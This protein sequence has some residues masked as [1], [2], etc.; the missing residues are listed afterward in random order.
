MEAAMIGYGK[1]VL[2]VD[3]DGRERQETALV[4]QQA[5]F[6]VV[7]ASDGLLALSK[8]QQRRFD[9]VVTDF[10]MPNLNGL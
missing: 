8:M 7:L 5:G 10:H 9:A 2:V 3:D 4:L 6:M 1:R